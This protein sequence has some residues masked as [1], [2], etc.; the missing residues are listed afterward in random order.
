MLQC[1]A[2]VNHKIQRHAGCNIALRV[3]PVADYHAGGDA[4]FA[5]T[6]MVCSDQRGRRRDPERSHLRVRMTLRVED[7]SLV[8]PGVG[9][10]M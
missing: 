4:S 5:P 3:V 1:V 2:V 9:L 8:R 6:N 7:M 10:M